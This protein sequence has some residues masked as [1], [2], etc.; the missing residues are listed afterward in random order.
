MRPVD[1]IITPQ[2]L[3]TRK[4]TRRL[5][6]QKHYQAPLPSLFLGTHVHA[7]QEQKFI[8]LSNLHIHVSI[9]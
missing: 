7:R 6:R 4:A 1:L 3:V 9:I 2:V 8:T 5:A